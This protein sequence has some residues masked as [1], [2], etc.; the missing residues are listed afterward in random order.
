MPDV[1]LSGSIGG[2]DIEDDDATVLS[3]VRGIETNALNES[4]WE[5]EI[6]GCSGRVS[7]LRGCVTLRP[8]T[9]NEAIPPIPVTRLHQDSCD[10]R[11]VTTCT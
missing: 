1:D 5:N 7:L 4:I 9:D 2:S 6:I 3:Y 11:L 10:I 8:S